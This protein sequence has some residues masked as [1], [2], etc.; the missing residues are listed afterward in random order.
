MLSVSLFEVYWIEWGWLVVVALAIVIV[1]YP[2]KSLPALQLLQ[3]EF[4]VAAIGSALLIVSCLG[5]IFVDREFHFG[6]W[7]FA[8]RP[9]YYFVYWGAMR[10]G[11]LP[12]E[13]SVH[14]VDWLVVCISLTFLC[15]LLM[16][17]YAITRRVVETRVC[18]INHLCLN[19]NYNLTANTSGV[20]PECGTPIGASVC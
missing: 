3:R 15:L 11:S 16:L 18:Q 9:Q 17:A 2:P 12:E 6:D 14:T 5:G 19:C 1:F 13:L 4:L 20:C 8:L 10:V 7:V